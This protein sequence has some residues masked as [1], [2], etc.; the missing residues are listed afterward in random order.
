MV[1]IT[2]KRSGMDH[3]AFNLQRTPWLPL[4]RKRS[5][6]GASTKC[7][8]GHII[9]AH[10]SFIDP[11]K[12]KGWVGLVDWPI[13]DGLPTQVVN[14]QLQVERRTAKER[15]PETDVL[16]LSHAD[17][18]YTSTVVYVTNCRVNIKTI[19]WHKII[20]ISH[21]LNTTKG[22]ITGL[23]QFIF[24]TNWGSVDPKNCEVKNLH[25]LESSKKQSALCIVSTVELSMAPFS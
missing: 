5:P 10:Y 12:M 22:R 8:G 1:Q 23:S 19:Y 3:T 15:Y 13:A 2:L 24:K 25:N 7:G 18:P 6:D 17:Q 9:A 11:E 21:L 16:P 20:S 4:P 14:H